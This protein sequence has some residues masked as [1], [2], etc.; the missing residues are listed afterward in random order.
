MLSF[1]V[2][3]AVTVLLSYCNEKSTFI[4][5]MRLVESDSMESHFDRP[6]V[7]DRQ[8]VSEWP[9]KVRS[10]VSDLMACSV[11]RVRLL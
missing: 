10:T 2:L 3:G 11:L 9:L 5:K 6:V 1:I 8:F 4:L 7:K